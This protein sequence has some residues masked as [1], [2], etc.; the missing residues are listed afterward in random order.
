VIHILEIY[1]SERERENNQWKRCSKPVLR[2]LTAGISVFD[3]EIDFN[4][5]TP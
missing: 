3:Y 1:K 4:A 2:K 5:K